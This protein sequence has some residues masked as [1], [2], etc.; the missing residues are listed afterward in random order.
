MSR[1]QLDLLSWM[2]QCEA[3]SIPNGCRTLSVVNGPG[4]VFIV[5][6]WTGSYYLKHRIPLHFKPRC[7]LCRRHTVCLQ[8]LVAVLHISSVS[9]LLKC[10][11]I[12]PVRRVPCSLCPTLGTHYLCPFIK[13]AFYVLRRNHKLVALCKHKFDC[14]LRRADVGCLFNGY[15]SR[16]I[17][18]IRQINRMN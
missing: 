2:Y 10:G 18:N 12:A 13:I 7:V 1:R 14:K 15:M 16:K 6:Y 17:K 5:C 11:F 4:D 3:I 8:H 9:E